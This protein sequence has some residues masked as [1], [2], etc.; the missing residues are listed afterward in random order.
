MPTKKEHASINDL[1]L[2]PRNPRVR[3]ERS[4][5]MI[6]DSLKKFGGMRSIVL[7]ENNIV[8]AG[9]GTI[10]EAK[11]LGLDKVRIID[12]DGDEII[13]VRR[14]GLTEK[15]WIQYGVADNRS[16]DLS[17]WDSEILLEL[18]E[19]FDLEDYF[20]PDEIEDFEIQLDEEAGTSG[21]H[22]PLSNKRIKKDEENL[23][24]LLKD[25][26]AK[27]LPCRCKPGEIW[28]LGKHRLLV[29]DSTDQGA[30]AILMN[31]KLADVCCTDPPYGVSYKGKSAE[32]LEIE[33]DGAD[34]IEEF[35]EAAYKA[36]DSALKPGAAIYVF[37]PAGPLCLIFG[38]LWLKQGWLLRQTLVW[39]KNSMVMGHSDYHYKHEPCYFGYKPADYGLGRG[40]ANWYGDNAQT[41][42]IECDRPSKNKLHPTAKPTDLIAK[43][44]ENSCPPK[45]L[46]FEPFGGSGSCIIAAEMLGGVRVNA[47]ELSPDYATVIITRWEAYTGEKAEIL[48]VVGH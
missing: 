7:D 40:R 23:D 10:T 4:S 11:D 8:R 5:E 31:G 38:N 46:V 33:N 26:G 29:G 13:A 2:D 12:A 43:L 3:T 32:A 27:K 35:I 39:A 25:Q 14:K 20:T 47:C 48:E 17:E 37:H 30:I 34:S 16:S 45:G 22:E 19:E 21:H 41:S 9:N 1:K 15:D 24:Q 44:L 18:D 6:R 42:V 28:Q 36:I